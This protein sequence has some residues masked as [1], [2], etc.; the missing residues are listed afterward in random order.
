MCKLSA[1]REVVR[2]HRRAVIV[3]METLSP[4]CYT[5]RKPYKPVMVNRSQCGRRKFS[6]LWNVKARARRWYK[7]GFCKSLFKL[8]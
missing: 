1:D 3:N 7:T 2:R 4:L 6:T 8:S 5:D